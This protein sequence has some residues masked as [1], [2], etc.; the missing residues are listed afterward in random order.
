MRRWLAWNLFFRLQERAKGHPTFRILREMEAADRLGSSE[1]AQLQAARLRELLEY[2]YAHVPFVRDGMRG[3]GVSPEHIQGPGDLAR[4]PLTHKADV[5]KYRQ[6]LRSEI[7]GHLA[8]FTTGGSTGEP[9][10]FDLAKRR[11]AS[12]VAC[13]QRVSRWWGVSVGDPEIA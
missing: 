11:I 2:C 5:R 4:L 9:L 7:A 1:L 10:I 3:A 12:R 6:Q 13:R 8:R